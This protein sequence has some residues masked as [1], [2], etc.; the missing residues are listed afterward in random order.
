[1]PAVREKHKGRGR[2][3]G[4]KI[5]RGRYT[6]RVLINY[7]FGV[8]THGNVASF[9]AAIRGPLRIPEACPDHPKVNSPIDMGGSG[10]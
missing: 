10:S 6:E 1:V 7:L 4:I 5:A 3:G 2:P 8:G 9:F